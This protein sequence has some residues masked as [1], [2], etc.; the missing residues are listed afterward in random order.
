MI[1]GRMG[2]A[3]V[4]PGPAAGPV[5]ES[6]GPACPGVASQ[7]CPTPRSGGTLEEGACAA[8]LES[9]MFWAGRRP[10]GL[11]GATGEGNPAASA[12]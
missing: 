4:S 3:F 8:P 7:G 9:G 6:G 1:R 11:E 2:L 5:G 10:S 12:Q